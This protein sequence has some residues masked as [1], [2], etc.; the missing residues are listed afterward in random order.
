MKTFFLEECRADLSHI[1]LSFHLVSSQLSGPQTSM[2]KSKK[3]EITCASSFACEH[4]HE[5]FFFPSLSS[6]SFDGIV[7]VTQSYETLPPELQS[8]K[9]PLQDYSS[10][11][12][13]ASSDLN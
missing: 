3:E 13:E 4:L 8:L 5:F 2:T 1:L 6:C 11:S 9:A 12:F 7:L 10:V